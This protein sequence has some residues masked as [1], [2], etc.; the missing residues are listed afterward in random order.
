MR[1]YPGHLFSRRIVLRLLGATTFAPLAL[2]GG[3][4]MPEDT[5]ARP[6]A[7]RGEHQPRPLPFDPAKLPGLSEK[8]LTSHH[9]N[10][11]TGAVK[12]LN[13]IEQQIGA[14]PKNAAPY[15]MGSLKREELIATNSML[16]HEAYFGNLG[17][18]GGANG[19]FATLIKGAYGST[20]AWEQDFRLTGMSLAG[21]SGWVI[22]SYDPQSQSLH[23]WWAF[24]HTHGIAGGTPVLV[25][26][27][28][29]HSY[30]MDY[31][32][33]AKGYIDAFFRNIEW[34]EVN[35]RLEGARKAA[36]TA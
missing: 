1:P 7:Y 14:V 34:D 35:R 9:Q 31:G 30:H 8:L 32:A 28:Y 21:G 5:T 20:E 6:L 25:M 27:M 11:Y 10:N 13:L 19:T 16:L 18:S 24:D 4:A 2:Q 17:G 15:Q 12:R 36:S 26:D 29:E 22:A 33:N 3:I 23:N